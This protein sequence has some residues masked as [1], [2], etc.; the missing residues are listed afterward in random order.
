MI[1]GMGFHGHGTRVFITRF[2]TDIPFFI[3]YDDSFLQGFTGEV[4]NMGRHENVGISHDNVS[5]TLLGL[6]GVYDAT[7]RPQFDLSS[8][9]FSESPRYIIERTGEVTL[10]EDIRF[11][12]TAS[13]EDPF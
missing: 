1:L 4:I 9:G 3:M 7:Y 11:D 5:H 6:M 12:T 10:L 8:K 13:E 2:V